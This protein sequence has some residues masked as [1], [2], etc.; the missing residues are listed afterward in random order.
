MHSWACPRV[1]IGTRQ[2]GRE[3]GHNVI[4][5]GYDA[6]AIE[7]AV[8]VQIQHGKYE[9][10]TLFGDGRAGARI[11]D[12]LAEGEFRIQKRLHYGDDDLAHPL[13]S[14]ERKVYKAQHPASHCLSRAA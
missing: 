7:R 1:N 5:V 12:I 8:R 9:R 14:G 13:W 10:S 3:R 11:A 2:Q 4:D 6:G